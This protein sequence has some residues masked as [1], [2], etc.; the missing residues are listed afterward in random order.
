MNNDILSSLFSSTCTQ[1]LNIVKSTDNTKGHVLAHTV[2][3]LEDVTITQI[4]T[5]PLGQC[6]L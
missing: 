3:G 4:K 2:Q 1:T 5:T 6:D